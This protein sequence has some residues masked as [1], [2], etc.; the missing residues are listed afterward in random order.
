MLSLLWL[1]AC[2]SFNNSKSLTVSVRSSLC[3]FL[4]QNEWKMIFIHTIYYW[5]TKK[6]RFKRGAITLS[7]IIHTT[8]S[9][10][11]V[12]ISEEKKY[13]IHD[14][15]V[16]D[17]FFFPSWKLNYS[18]PFMRKKSEDIP[19]KLHI[20]SLLLPESVSNVCINDGNSYS[21]PCH[22]HTHKHIRWL[23]HQLWLKYSW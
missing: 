11:D 3:F 6:K 5:R 4:V 12:S 15:C 8:T 17:D 1:W 16:W 13:N 22:T 23:W 10:F 18:F 9:Y 7:Y 2:I 20:Y 14:G 21:P 19:L